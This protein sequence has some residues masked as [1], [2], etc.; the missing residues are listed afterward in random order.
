[1]KTQD[2]PILRQWLRPL[3]LGLC[4][5]V[6]V[7]TL[8]LLLTALVFR[9]VEI[10]HAAATPLAVTA[11][12]VGAFGAGL[13]AA[14]TARCR[15]LAVGALCGA[16]LFLI[17]LTAGLIRNGDLD[18]GFALAKAAVLTLSGGIGGVL[19]VGRKHR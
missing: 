10:P 2:K 13:T 18:P 4:V 12:A 17:L 8:I 1:M 3:G 7:G 6:V 11:A 15:G 14:L 16:G 5:G 19:G 9:S